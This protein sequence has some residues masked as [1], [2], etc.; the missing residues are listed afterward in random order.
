V[1]LLNCVTV[2]PETA[3]PRYQL[4]LEGVLPSSVS[5]LPCITPLAL[6]AEHNGI[7]GVKQVRYYAAGS[8][9]KSSKV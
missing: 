7:S 4:D 5:M 9:Q 8:D 3:L 1:K 6:V 2:Q